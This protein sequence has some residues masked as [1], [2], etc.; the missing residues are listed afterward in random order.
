M[1]EMTKQQVEDLILAIDLLINL[2]INGA[3]NMSFE[4]FTQERDRVIQ[5]ACAA[6]KI[7]DEEVEAEEALR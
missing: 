1:F 7:K 6:M 3:R 4:K 5:M 2:R